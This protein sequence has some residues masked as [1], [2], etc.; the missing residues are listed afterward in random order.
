[1]ERTHEISIDTLGVLR[2]ACTIN[3]GT[4]ITPAA[5]ADADT[6]ELTALAPAAIILTPDVD[7]LS[8]HVA[9]RTAFPGGLPANTANTSGGETGNGAVA[10]LGMKL[11]G[12]AV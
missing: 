1:V 4:C 2:L 3:D 8:V 9:S 5:S 7:E 10:S 6:L 12:R 11:N